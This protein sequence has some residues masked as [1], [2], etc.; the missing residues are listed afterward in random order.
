MQNDTMTKIKELMKEANAPKP[1]GVSLEEHSTAT[2]DKFDK[3]FRKLL[4]DPTCD[5]TILSL[6]GASLEL[7]WRGARTQHIKVGMLSLMIAT[8][9]AVFTDEKSHFVLAKV[10]EK[11][12]E[13]QK[14]IDEALARTE[15]LKTLSP[16]DILNAPMAA[17][18]PNN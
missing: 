14:H 6:I 9:N 16:D 15:T 10:E 2:F 8:A 12:A 7:Q 13:W 17:G 4:A 3:S 5:T 1:D 11:K 18:I